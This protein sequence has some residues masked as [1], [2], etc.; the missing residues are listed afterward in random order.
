M[1]ANNTTTTTVEPLALSSAEAAAFLG[2]SLKTLR[3]LVKNGLPYSE[4]G[5]RLWR[6]S[7]ADLES[8]L[9]SRRRVQ[10]APSAS[11]GAA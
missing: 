10:S 6:F 7:R 2:V 1:V 8:Y 3:T 11:E 5:P 4:L 9:A